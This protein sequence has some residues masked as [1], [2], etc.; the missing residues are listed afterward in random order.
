MNTV[1]LLVLLGVRGSPEPDPG[2]DPDPGLGPSPG[3]GRHCSP[4]GGQSSSRLVREEEDGRLADLTSLSWQLSL[5]ATLCYTYQECI[6]NIH[7]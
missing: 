3:P 4:G 5:G 7:R 1:L 2:P 6:T